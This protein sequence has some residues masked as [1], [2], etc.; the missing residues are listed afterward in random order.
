MLPPPETVHVMVTGP[1]QSVSAGPADTD[2]VTD[3]S[4]DQPVPCAVTAVPVGPE[5]LVNVSVPG[6]AASTPGV[7]IEEI[8]T[9][10]AEVSSITRNMELELRVANSKHATDVFVGLDYLMLFC[11]TELHIRTKG[12]AVQSQNHRW[13]IDIP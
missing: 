4:G 5:Y 2:K 12:L 9:N 1:T 7:Q 10:S 3:V 11:R 8:E 13:R 6:G